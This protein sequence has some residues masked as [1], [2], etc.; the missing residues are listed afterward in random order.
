MNEFEQ[1]MLHTY[2]GWKKICKAPQISHSS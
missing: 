1:L 2:G